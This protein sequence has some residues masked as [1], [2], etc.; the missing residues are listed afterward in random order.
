MI[1]AELSKFWWGKTG[2]SSK[3][4]WV[5]WDQLCKAKFEGGMGFREFESFNKAMLA[6]QGWRL[7]QYPNSLLARVLK[8]KYYRRTSFS[9]A[10]AYP[11]HL[12]HGKAL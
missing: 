6:K 9:E 4:H 10:K 2:N 8:S 5:S 1:N 7:L 12:S 3:I 11:T